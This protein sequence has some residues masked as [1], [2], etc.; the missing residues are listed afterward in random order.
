MGIKARRGLLLVAIMSVVGALLVSVGVTSP[1]EAEASFCDQPFT[2]ETTT[3]EVGA[4]V[5][6]G[7]TFDNS[8]SI[9]QSL[10]FQD[11]CSRSQRDYQR[12]QRH[13]QRI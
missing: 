8:S 9:S 13:A 11:K 12:C 2:A 7:Q 10:P 4:A 1:K 3:P 5:A 6:S